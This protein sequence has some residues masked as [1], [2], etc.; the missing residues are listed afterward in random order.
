M[1]AWQSDHWVYRGYDLSTPAACCGDFSGFVAHWRERFGP[2][3]S[4]P[5]WNRFRLDE[6]TSWWG[7]MSLLRYQ[8]SPV[9]MFGVLWGTQLTEWFKQDYTN[10]WMS[11]DIVFDH[12]WETEKEYY[13][14]IAEERM[15]G[16]SGGDVKLRRQYMR[17]IWS[18]EL[19]VRDETGALCLFSL[20]I[21]YPMGANIA[22]SAPALFETA[23][24]F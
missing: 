1:D 14:R 12:W 4:L 8:P 22:L 7:R 11:D 13:A 6:M 17:S 19:P 24:R 16:L 21:D 23:T 20:H 2:D 5:N 3:G 9:N 15:I 18:M 10:K